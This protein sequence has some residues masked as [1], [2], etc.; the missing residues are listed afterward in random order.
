MSI[1]K[2]CQDNLSEFLK[3]FVP[4]FV[5]T[6]SHRQ[7]IDLTQSLLTS[8]E[9]KKVSF[10]CPPRIGKSSNTIR[11]LAWAAGNAEG[12]LNHITCTYGL[13]L[14][15]KHQD[16][17]NRTVNSPEFKAVFGSRK[18]TLPLFTSLTA[19]GTGV[20]A[21]SDLDGSAFRGV[22]LFDDMVK[23][24]TREDL[25][26]S[27]YEWYSAVACSRL[28]KEYACLNIGTRF[29]VRDFTHLLRQV[30]GEYDPHENPEGFLFRN[31][32][33]LVNDVSAFPGFPHL[34]T[35]R[36]LRMRDSPNTC[37]TFCTVY[38]GDPESSIELEDAI[39]LS[40]WCPEDPVLD[41]FAVVTPSNSLD[42]AT[43][44]CVF[45]LLS[46]GCLRLD[47]YYELWGVNTSTSLIEQV[48]KLSLPASGLVDSVGTGVS[49]KYTQIN[50]PQVKRALM[51]KAI[52]GI[53]S[54]QV[55]PGLDAE[56]FEYQIN[57]YGVGVHEKLA[58]CAALAV[59]Y[60]HKISDKLKPTTFFNNGKAAASKYISL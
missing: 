59:C 20:A 1:K 54:M 46:S 42:S 13:T 30:E 10:N 6:D 44:V 21:G 41:S 38:Q 34:S 25:P 22:L 19:T 26:T 49:L 14:S 53:Q 9:Q 31:Y 24:V 16:I 55:V 11:S 50:T 36:L 47:A 17:W 45:S 23:T 39:S 51:R 60:Y 37:E 2:L 4:N 48:S 3:L 7:L 29:G 18:L 12:C 15:G 40:I 43:G 33:A 58:E 8:S 52:S 5:L 56:R 35:E 28:Q 32:P 27:V 57:N